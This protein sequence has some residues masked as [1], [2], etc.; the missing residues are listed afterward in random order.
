MGSRPF[1]SVYQHQEWRKPQW[2]FHGVQTHH[3]SS[4]S[5]R[6]APE[7]RLSDILHSIGIVQLISLTP[8]PQPSPLAPNASQI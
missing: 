7:L 8:S 1:S 4:V 2:A 6:S 5:P 3:S